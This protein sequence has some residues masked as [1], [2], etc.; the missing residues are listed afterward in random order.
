M[1]SRVDA[2]LGGLNIQR[3]DEILNSVFGP[4]CLSKIALIIVFATLVAHPSSDVRHL[5]ANDSLMN[6]VG[7]ITAKIAPSAFCGW[8]AVC[9]MCPVLRPASV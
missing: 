3:A 1:D 9:R 4:S 7:G 8:Y 5:V 6:H 2:T